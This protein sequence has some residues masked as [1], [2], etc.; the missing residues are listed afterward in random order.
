M[1]QFM[2]HRLHIVMKKNIINLRMIELY[3]L[4]IALLMLSFLAGKVSAQA[5]ISVNPGNTIPCG[6]TATLTAS[7]GTAYLWSTAATTQAIMTGVAG[8]Y[9][10]TIT[11]G[12]GATASASTTLIVTGDVTPPVAKCDTITVQ[13][14]ANGE[15]LV[16]LDD[17]DDGSFDACSQVTLNVADWFTAGSDCASA[18]CVSDTM[19]LRSAV[20]G[21]PG[22]YTSSCLSNFSPE[23][24][25]YFQVT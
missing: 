6:T 12:A 20:G 22:S 13:L 1:I 24:W 11:D 21:L 23:S 25:M 18:V 17:V 8:I 4:G 9:T 7:M 19:Q 15:V 5:G 16:D 14:D 3:R 10:V 2:H